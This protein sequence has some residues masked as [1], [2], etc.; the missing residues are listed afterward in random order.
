VV[1]DLPHH[2]LVEGLSPVTASGKVG[3]KVAVWQPFCPTL[4]EE[5]IE[6]FVWEEG[7]KIRLRV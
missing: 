3:Q 2:P 5:D 4:W 7:R 6:K 1:E